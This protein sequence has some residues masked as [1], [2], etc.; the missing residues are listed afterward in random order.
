MF[1]HNPEHPSSSYAIGG[2]EDIIASENMQRVSTAFNYVA[3]ARDVSDRIAPASQFR[4]CD[5][6]S[7]MD[8]LGRAAGNAVLFGMNHLR[9]VRAERLMARAEFLLGTSI[10]G[11]D[12]KDQ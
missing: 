5:S 7:T 2:V 4:P 8:N 12:E 3:K 11:Q 9:I 1:E 10:L 6:P